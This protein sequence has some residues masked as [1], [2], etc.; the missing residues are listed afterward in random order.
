M[1]EH[2]R[3]YAHLVGDDIIE[4]T[5]AEHQLIVTGWEHSVAIVIDPLELILLGR[6][7]INLGRQLDKR[8][9]H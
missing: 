7:M 4:Y 5:A 1:V 8:E 3:L 9:G 2:I 6:A